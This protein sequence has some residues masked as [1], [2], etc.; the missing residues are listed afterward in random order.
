MSHTELDIEL[1]TELA[2][3]LATELDTQHR[4]TK[5]SQLERLGA[6]CRTLQTAGESTDL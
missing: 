6:V 3:E 2:T 4:E 1:D 5:I